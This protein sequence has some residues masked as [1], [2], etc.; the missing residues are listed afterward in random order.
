MAEQAINT[1]YGLAERPD[2]FCDRLIKNFTLRAF[3]S[4]PKPPAEERSTD[5]VA[6]EVDPDAMSVDEDS[7]EPVS[8]ASEKPTS[9]GSADEDKDV[10]DAFELSQ[11][12]F[13]VGHVAIKQIV[14]LELVERE[15]K[16]QKAEREKGAPQT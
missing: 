15:W 7:A 5:A 12:L 6:P 1:V 13:V 4:K 9:Q 8:A 11:L 14:F 16:R 3:N 2:I 10:G